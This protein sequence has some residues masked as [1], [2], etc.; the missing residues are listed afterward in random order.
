MNK[1][2]TKI[3]KKKYTW[4]ITGGAGFIGSNLIERLLKNN[5]KVVCIDNLF[6]GDI[7][8]IKIFL[9]NKN[10]NFIKKDI[11]EKNII[12][13]QLKADFFIHLAA[14]GSVPRSIKDPYETNDVNLNGSMNM[15]KL[16]SELNCKRFVFAS[17][18][19]VY[20]EGKNKIKKETDKLSP[21]SPYGLSKLFFE[22]Y[23]EN[24]SQ[25]TNLKSIGLRFFNVF[26]PK[27]N[28]NGPYAAV[29]AQWIKNSLNKKKLILNGDGSTTRDFTY[30]SNVVDG[31]ICCCFFNSKKNYLAINLACGKE[32][33]LLELLKILKYLFRQKSIE[34]K[35]VKKPFR[36]GD[37]KKSKANIN[38]AKKLISYNPKETFRNGL[39][40]YFNHIINEKN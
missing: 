2:L 38:L 18:S 11:R 13:K 4:I 12:K 6:S 26:G 32:I 40:K 17:S 30:V 29:I 34:I 37:I 20:G 1:Y 19:S 33:S 31:I 8:N 7:K 24:I 27:Q 21:I 9:K 5:Q 3:S 10:F 25:N 15:F 35:I 28:M 14:L 39:I 22:K 16:A 23:I 36:N